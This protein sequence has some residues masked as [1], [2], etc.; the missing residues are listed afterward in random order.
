ML[1]FDVMLIL[2]AAFTELFMDPFFLICLPSFVQ[3]SPSVS[4]SLSLFLVFMLFTFVVHSAVVLTGE[5][6]IHIDAV[7]DPLSPSGQKLAS[8]LQILMKHF[9]PS[10]R[11]IL[12]P[13]V[14]YVSGYL[15]FS[16]LVISK[17]ILCK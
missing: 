11:I 10:M 16:E 8:L 3:F 6:P 1:V 4:S 12:N 2:L 9:Q 7:I 5:S 14:S 15:W 17:L 13:L